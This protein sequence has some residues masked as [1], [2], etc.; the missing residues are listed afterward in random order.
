MKKT[1][2][3]FVLVQLVFAV[4]VD[5][6]KW[7]VSN[8]SGVDADATTIQNAHDL[9]AAGDTIYVEGSSVSYGDLNLVKKVY[10]YGPGYYLGENPETQA[11]ISPAYIET[12]DFSAGSDGSIVSGLYITDAV[13]INASNVILKRNKIEG[14]YTIDIESAETNVLILQNFINAASYDLIYVTSGCS[15]IMIHN[16]YIRHGGG[17]DAIE[18]AGTAVADITNNVIYGDMN[19]SNSSF[20]NNIYRTGTLTG[21][22]NVY[23]NNLCNGTQFPSGNGNQQVVDMGTVFVASGSTDGQ[24]QLAAGSPAIGAGLSGEDCGM[25]GGPDPYVLSGIPNIPSIY[26][27]TAPTSASEATGLPV[28]IKVKSNK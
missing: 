26:Y 1:F 21:S 25:F 8:K 2:L 6:K 3:L 20:T 22:G 13:D 5:A 10:I 17:Y 27:F 14:S 15:N 19:V 24:W 23:Y 4:T 9:A 28:H 16:N 18:V 12:L 7:T 11:N